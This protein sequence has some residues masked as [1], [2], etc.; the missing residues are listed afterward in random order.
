MDKIIQVS[1]V[2]IVVV[3]G[4]IFMAKREEAY[5]KKE[6]ASKK[7]QEQAKMN[8]ESNDIPM[9]AKPVI[10]NEL[11]GQY[12][13]D[14][15]PFVSN[16][17]RIFEMWVENDCINLCKPHDEYKYKYPKI[18]GEKIVIPMESIKFFT[19]EG[20][21]RVDNI[22]EGGGVSLGGAIVGGV[23]AGGAGAIIGGRKKITTTAKEIDERRTYLYYS[24][25]NKD[26]RIVFTSKAYDI[27]L[28]LIPNK[29]FGFIE[30]NKIVESNK[31]KEKNSVY[32]DI[33]QLAKLK[34]KGILT[35]IEFDEKKKVL[36]EKIQ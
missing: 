35:D 20:E 9:Y 26:I 32:D 7:L 11:N 3:G 17:G 34:D 8:G 28:N 27:L 23:I 25:N 4:L 29:D 30:K 13:N 36:L 18:G 22:V 2:L 24:K 21:H 12:Y 5:K 6:E 1:V 15:I 14:H 33:E 31:P 19:R 10:C 16:R